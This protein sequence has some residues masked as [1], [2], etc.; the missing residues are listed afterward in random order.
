MPYLCCKVCGDCYQLKPGESSDDYGICHC[1]GE[2]FYTETKPSDYEEDSVR[3]SSSDSR[4]QRR[5][6]IVLSPLIVLMVICASLVAIYMP[7]NFSGTDP[8]VIGSDYRGDVTKEVYPSNTSAG[9]KVV[10]IVTGIHPREKLSIR[11]S[12]DLTKKYNLSPDQQIIHYRIKVKDHPEIFNEGRSNG[13]ALAAQYVLPDIKKTKADVVIVFHDHEPGYG[14]GYFIAT[15]EM[16]SASVSYAEKIRNGLGD[17]NY[18]KSSINSL[19]GTSAIRFSNPVAKAGYK[20]LVYEIP[21]LDSY[22]KAYNQSK[23][24]LDVSFRLI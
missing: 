7:L 12:D 10:V 5:L 20:T 8:T 1:G 13:E 4:R 15:P 9:S 3:H 16:D 11:V 19:H 22:Q 18:Y 17:F 2:I 14:E 21:G 24:L 6:I 23:R